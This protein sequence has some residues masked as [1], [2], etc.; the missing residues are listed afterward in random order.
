MNDTVT[1]SKTAEIKALMFGCGNMGQALMSGWRKAQNVSFT[2]VDPVKPEIGPDVKVLGSAEEVEGKFDLIIIAVKPQLIE[3]IS[4]DAPDAMSS[5]RLVLSIAAGTST[6]T[7]GRLLGDRPIVRMMPNMPASVSLGLS[8]LYANPA[9]SEDD[10]ALIEKL[11]TENGKYI[12]LDE[13]DKIDR[14]TS[15]AGSGPGYVFE[16]LRLFTMAAMEQGFSEEDARMLAIGTV[17]GTAKMAEESS[18]TLEDLRNSVTSKNGTTQ[19]GLEQLMKD[20]QLKDL[21]SNT[22]SAAYN[23]AVELR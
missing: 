13:E 20:D 4:K 22:V 7:L 21:F 19:A 16:I 14:F 11:A 12:W 6:D 23:R 15:V 10:K 3:M 8:G 18:K 9:C 5:G 1:M 17:L 2:V